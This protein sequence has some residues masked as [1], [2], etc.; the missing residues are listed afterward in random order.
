M[1]EKAVAGGL[2]RGRAILI[3]WILCVFIG[4]FLGTCPIVHAMQPPRPGEI[5]A[6]KA[7]GK[8]KKRLEFVKKLG[9]HKMSPRLVRRFKEKTKAIRR[10]YLEAQGIVMEKD[11][12]SGQAGLQPSG[13]GFST[14]DYIPPADESKGLPTTGSPR[15]FAL[16]ISFADYP[17]TVSADT[18][19][20]MLWGDGDA[21]NYPR[22]SLTNY[23]HRSSYGLLD[24]SNGHTFAWY[25]TAYDR[26]QVLTTAAGREALIKEALEYFDG[27]G[28]DFS[29]YDYD[30]DGDIDYFVVFWTGPDTDWGTFWWAYKTSWQATPSPILDG[31]T[32]GVYSWQWEADA[33]TV[34]IHE[35]GH[36]LGL[37]D[38]YDYDSDVGPDGGVG[39]FDMM[40]ANRADHNCFSKWLFGWVTPTVVS[41]GS[42]VIELHDTTTTDCVLIWPGIGLDDMFSEFFMVQN[43]QV[44]GNDED[45]G[46]APDGLAIWH[47][48]AT[49]NAAGTRFAYDNS[50]T[51]HKLLRLME[52]DGLEEIENNGSAGADDLYNEL[53]LFSPASFPSSTKYNGYD[54]CVRVWNIV[55]NGDSPGATITATFDFVCTCDDT[56]AAGDVIMPAAGATDV[57]TT[58]TLNWTWVS[59]ST[60]Y[61]V[62]VCEDINCSVI[63]ASASPTANYWN[64]SPPLGDWQEYW[65]RVRT[66]GTCDAS[67]WS[68]AWHFTTRCEAPPVAIAQQVLP[69]D[70][71]VDT[72]FNTKLVWNWVPGAVMYNIAVYSDA[73]CE[74]VIRTGLVSYNE[75]VG[76]GSWH[77]TPDLEPGTQY[78]WKVQSV[79]KCQNG[80]WS[81]SWSFTTHPVFPAPDLMSPAD[82]AVHQPLTPTFQWEAVPEVTR[83][84]LQICGDVDC[85]NVFQEVLPGDTQF[86]YTGSLDQGTTYYWRVRAD[87]GQGSATAGPWS[88]VRSFETCVDVLPPPASSL[89][90][91]TGATDVS[92][93]PTLRWDLPAGDEFPFYDVEICTDSAYANLV[94]STHQSARQWT[95]SPGLDLDT[96]YYWRVRSSNACGESDW[97]S[98]SFTIATCPVPTETPALTSP[99]FGEAD[100]S[101]TPTL[102]WTY[103]LYPVF[104]PGNVE[105]CSDP[106]C[107]TVVRS[108]VGVNGSSW[109]VTPALEEDTQYWWRISY[110]NTCGPGPWSIISNFRTVACVAP[111][112][113]T[114]GDPGG[115]VDSGASY[116][117]TWT[118]PDSAVSFTIQEST[119]AS[120]SRDT[121][122]SF[123]ETG[124]SRT[125]SHINADCPTTTY[126]YRVKA[127]SDCDSSV[128]SNTVT[129][130][131]NGS[132]VPDTPS[133][134]AP[135]HRA[136][137]MPLEPTLDWEDV[138]NADHYDVRV[139]GDS[140]CNTI[141]R[142]QILKDTAWTVSPALD[143]DHDYWW[144]VQAEGCGA[145]A[146]SAAWKFTTGCAP[147]V[148]TDPGDV[149]SSGQT[150]TVSWTPVQDATGYTLQEDE[151][152]VFSRPT[153][154][155][156][157]KDTSM[158]LTAPPAVCVPRTL[159]YRVMATSPCGLAGWSETVDIEIEAMPL[160]TAPVLTDPSDGAT[161]VSMAPTLDWKDAPAAEDYD[162]FVCAD[163]GCTTVIREATVTE[164]T[165]TVT[166]S[167]PDAT[168]LWW[169]VRAKNTCGAVLSS[170]FGFDTCALPGTPT[171]SDSGTS[172]ASGQ[173]YTLTWTAI[174]GAAEY[175]IEEATNPAFS[176]AILFR[177]TETSRNF[178]HE[179]AGCAP[180]TYYYRVKAANDCGQSPV[181]ETVDMA[182][183]GLDTDRDGVCDLRDNCPDIPNKDQQDS[184][185]DGIGDACD[186]CPFDFD[187]DRDTDGGDLAAFAHD[188]Q[189]ATLK[190][191]AARFGTLCH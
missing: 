180:V 22:E 63:V 92:P 114:A 45:S 136:T 21:S 99:S 165:W 100:V 3:A 87:Q 187:R 151:D 94:R 191:F 145:S 142:T 89:D 13:G 156:F 36:A 60:S 56:P 152:P 127:H 29:Q 91:A 82:G 135:A 189:G 188:N 24:L 83:Y 139:C 107:E 158:T 130:Q 182:V 134:V 2:Q 122:E 148:I 159:Y 61:T 85:T 48:D 163:G 179:N 76:S 154:Y 62:Q 96:L 185:L 161:D 144:Q 97:V 174:H 42:Q 115:A 153:I 93:T 166:P 35:T 84:K 28:H 178:S 40:H 183:N 7:Q 143:A 141:L 69:A 121:T 16:L 109:T 101:V 147:P 10:K 146:W 173:P 116:P 19:D 190:A 1:K 67:D 39:G 55:D 90:P 124:T 128:W 54:S 78:W 149:I 71:A 9:N 105:V 8:Y 38:Y 117:V 43:R 30:G 164:S 44:S 58:P 133:L 138:F 170:R 47:V 102:Q 80:D 160:P 88:V 104:D 51:A 184:D 119:S 110:S 113:P 132:G 31:K 168:A 68:P 14:S 176:D 70:N 46:F 57:S 108:A 120:F 59:G 137:G 103:W 167:L 15:I 66:N 172:V 4:F 123:T 175:R 162:V 125:F 23:Y 25:Q 79:N 18:I 73:A 171:L 17:N 86:T 52:A 74:N 49:L 131:V 95:V 155:T 27:Q 169:Y 81:G 140:H 26:S 6:L 65:W 157:D 5:A 11:E 64:V 72:A 181:S 77:V 177:I 118:Q 41:N 53:N 75:A 106:Q 129:M 126:Y 37:P 12:A 98:A 32:L 112:A 150:Y 33:P 34:V 20:D 50:Y 186:A 111:G